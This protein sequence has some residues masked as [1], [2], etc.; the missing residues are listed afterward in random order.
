MTR[1]IDFEG[2]ENFRDFGGYDTAS[3]RSLKRNLLFRSANH[4]RATDEDLAAMAALGI[5][6]V[7]DLRRKNERE[8][9]PSRR[10]TSFDA[11]VIDND[12]DGEHQ[13]WLE[14]VK[15]SDLSPAWFHAHSLD[16]YRSAPL[17]TRHLDLFTRYFQALAATDGPVLVHCA[18]GK[19]RTGLICAFTHHIAG[20]HRDDLLADYML[21]NDEDRIARRAGLFVAWASELLGRPLSDAAARTALSVHPDYLDT[22]IAAIDAAYGSLDVYLEKALGVDQALREKIQA[23]I[24]A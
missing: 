23:Q 18:A 6:V 22:A 15:D 16:Y 11:A 3:G 21:T 14:F 4:A 13:D 5:R 10:W 19:D 8:R 20:V 1:H 9:E 24:L 7:V 17:E 12:L 2:V